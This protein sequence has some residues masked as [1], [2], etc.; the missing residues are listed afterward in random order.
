[1]KTSR[2]AGSGSGNEKL[3]RT[4]EGLLQRL[5]NSTRFG[6]ILLAV[7]LVL[8]VGI[9]D[10]FSGDEMSILIFYLLPV[11]LSA[12]FVGRGAGAAVSILSG[13]VWSTMDFLTSR[14][15]SH[16]LIPYWNGLVMSGFFLVTALTLSSLKKALDR[17]DALAREI[18]EGLL[19]AAIRPMA[20]YQ[21][22]AAWKPEKNIGGDYYDIIDL[23]PTRLGICIA[24]VIGHGIPA[25]ILM[26][27]LQASIRIY[28]AQ[29]LEPRELCA[30]VNEF[31]SRNV[32]PGKFITFFYGIL[33][34]DTDKFLFSNAG[35]PPTL[36]FK[37]DGK[38]LKL[39]TADPVL[40]QFSSIEYHQHELKLAAGDIVIL[41]T[42]GLLEMA[43]PRGDFFGEERLAAVV[44]ANMQAE[45]QGLCDTILAAVSGFANG[46]FRDDL[47]F[48]VVKKE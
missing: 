21:I 36:V 8:A 43:N 29:S 25:A 24:D 44:A 26:A 35:H 33:D 15:Y 2:N 7:F 3:W 27:N 13:A 28:A 14:T 45:A 38:I 31:I 40:G 41:Y 39:D 10:F 22:A 42:D 30:R 16:V 48:V 20:G 17:E 47:T 23:G 12:W 5:T 32:G 37:R 19:P 18:Q 46:L 1:M 11:S 4:T 9:A 34:S 6:Y